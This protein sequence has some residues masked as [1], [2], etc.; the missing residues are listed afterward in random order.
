MGGYNLCYD[1]DK[2]NSWHWAH[3]TGTTTSTM[4]VINGTNVEVFT[5]DNV[6]STGWKY[7]GYTKIDLDKLEDNRE[8]YFSF[9][10]WS[11][12]ECSIN[13]SAV[14]TGSALNPLTTSVV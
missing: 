4:E 14:M 9:E 10:V 8:Y 7:L 2:N 11:S 5:R 1:T 13:F 12:I 3:Q 6:E